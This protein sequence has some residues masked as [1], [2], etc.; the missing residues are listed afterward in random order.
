MIHWKV[1]FRAIP[2]NRIVLALIV[3]V[4][5]DMHSAIPPAGAA[6]APLPRDGDILEVQ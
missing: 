4:A 6:A 3:P 5:R 1:R 2:R